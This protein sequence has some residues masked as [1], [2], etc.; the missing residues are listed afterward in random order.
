[1]HEIFKAERLYALCFGPLRCL[2]ATTSAS[3]RSERGRTQYMIAPLR[4]SSN[5]GP[6]KSGLEGASDRSRIVVHSDG[7]NIRLLKDFTRCEEVYF[8]SSGSNFRADLHETCIETLFQSTRRTAS[9]GDVSCCYS[10]Y[11]P[12]FPHPCIA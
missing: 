6:L 7:E 11:S 2:K 5:I 9:S 4:T 10:R 3:P 8:P 1:M 12:V